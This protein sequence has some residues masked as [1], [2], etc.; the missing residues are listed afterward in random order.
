MDILTGN[1]EN[2]A[3]FGILFFA[4]YG[5]VF[6][7]PWIKKLLWPGHWAHARRRKYKQN[8]SRSAADPQLRLYDRILQTG[9]LHYGY[10]DD[11][12]MDGASISFDMIRQ[13]QIR[14]AEH[15]L[16]CVQA[17]VGSKVLDVGCGMGGLLT[18]LK[19]KGYRPTGLTPDK[20]QIRHIRS[21][22]PDMPLIHARFQDMD[23]TGY[24]SGFNSI[25]FSE[26]FQYIPAVT[27]LKLCATLLDDTGEI[28]I[29]DY[30]RMEQAHEKSGHIWSEF[31]HIV[32][33]S[34]FEMVH[35][36]DISDNIRP[37]LAYAHF[38]A[39]RFGLPLFEFLRLK[40]EQ[41]HPA[42]HYIMEELIEGW[43]DKITHNIQT[44]DPDRFCKEKRYF[45]L[46]L[47]RKT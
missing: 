7:K 22:Q 33:D 13:A 28:I 6:M 43:H 30:F 47:V 32:L 23:A 35:K 16:D 4:Q 37:T 42:K 21:A 25:I 11:P 31:E 46:R 3:V 29:V 40:L 34:S 14:Y 10:F 39:T 20:N 45:L 5:T 26:S 44:I 36:E 17:P 41:K 15:L 9:F 18:M 24:T 1:F 12:D 8:I 2:I 38:F 27:A 19:E